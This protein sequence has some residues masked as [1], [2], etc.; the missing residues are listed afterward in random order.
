[1]KYFKVV[2]VLVIA[3]F[4][5]ACNINTTPS[6]TAYVVLGEKVICKKV[7]VFKDGDFFLEDC[8]NHPNWQ[9]L[10]RVYVSPK[11]NPPSS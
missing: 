7:E 9:K 11:W 4:I 6:P 2:I 1:M 3:V 8:N 5:T 10:A